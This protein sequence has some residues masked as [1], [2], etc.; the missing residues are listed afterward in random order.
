M[1]VEYASI[2]AR[3]IPSISLPRPSGRGTQATP[4]SRVSSHSTTVAA[5]A[6]N[7]PG[8]SRRHAVSSARH[9]PSLTVRVIR[10]IWL[11]MWS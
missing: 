2:C 6:C 4:N 5:T 7:A 1:R 10:A 9:R 8:T 11:W 3:V